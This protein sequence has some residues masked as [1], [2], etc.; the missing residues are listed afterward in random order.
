M[1]TKLAGGARDSYL[2]LVRTFPLTSIKS[3]AQLKEAQAVMDRM[4]AKGRLA[5]GE[6]TYLDALSDLVM[7]YE[8]THHPI[9]SPSDAD[10]LI[11]LMEAKGVTQ[12]ELHEATH[13][14]LSTI[15]EVRSGKRRFT[16]SMIGAMATYFGVEK[17][18]F[19]ANF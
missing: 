16:K 17:G 12:N 18:L 3:E 5:Q 19:A 2:A 7:A 15:S 14:S 9:P 13:I 4:L 8:N 10:L 6:L 11:H 1:A